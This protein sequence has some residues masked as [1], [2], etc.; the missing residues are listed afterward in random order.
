MEGDTNILVDGTWRRVLAI[1]RMEMH[2]SRP[3]KMGAHAPLKPPHLLG[4]TRKSSICNTG[5]LEQPVI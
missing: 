3:F 4:L 2:A 5:F 1:G